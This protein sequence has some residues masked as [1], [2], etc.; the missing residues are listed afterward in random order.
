[1]FILWMLV[2][3]YFGKQYHSCG[4]CK[5]LWFALLVVASF[6]LSLWILAHTQ[7]WLWNLKPLASLLLWFVFSACIFY[8]A[9]TWCCACDAG[10]N[11][12][13]SCTCTNCGSCNWWTCS[14]ET[15]KAA[16][17]K[18]AAATKTSGKKD[19]LKKIEGIG[20]AIEKHLHNGGILTFEDLMNAD[21][22]AVK[23]ILENAGKRFQMHDPSTWGIQSEYAVKGDW[24]GL[25]KYQDIL[26]WGKA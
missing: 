8:W 20:P 5:S 14:T 16:P 23:K 3:R 1:M 22:S 24:D 11:C 6:L 9:M 2:C 25:K 18:A 10:C 26:D 13:D 17:V 19:D 21:T 12:G 4:S 7:D 15:K